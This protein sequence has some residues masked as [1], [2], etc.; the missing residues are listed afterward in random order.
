[1][2]GEAE[3]WRGLLL[4]TGSELLACGF[5]ALVCRLETCRNARDGVLA[6]CGQNTWGDPLNRETIWGKGQEPGPSNVAP[7][8]AS[9][10]PKVLSACK[11][12]NI[13]YAGVG[14]N[15]AIIAQRGRE[16]T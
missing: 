13:I 14:G 15:Y 11:V 8:C 10:L 5:G 6:C 1:M 7:L 3:T 16:H 9:F 4:G 2:L 12:T